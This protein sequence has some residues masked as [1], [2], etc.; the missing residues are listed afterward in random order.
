M[1]RA[2]NDEQP[3]MAFVFDL[4]N[5]SR[6]PVTRQVIVAGGTEDPLVNR[7]DME[8]RQVTGLLSRPLHL[9]GNLVDHKLR[10][11]AVI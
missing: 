9:L 1:P 7:A 11:G 10:T 3:V 4:G 5:V 6:A 2:V 8:S